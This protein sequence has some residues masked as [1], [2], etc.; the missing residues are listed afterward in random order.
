MTR[1]L[2]ELRQI[3]KDVLHSFNTACPVGADRPLR[4]ALAPAAYVQA[5]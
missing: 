3:G 5:R 4:T 1:R 2:T